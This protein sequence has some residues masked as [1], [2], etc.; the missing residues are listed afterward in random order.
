MY[1][2]PLV[3]LVILVMSI[4]LSVS[5][6]PAGPPIE[7]IRG[8]IYGWCI[9]YLRLP[10]PQCLYSKVLDIGKAYKFRDP[11]GGVEE[12]TLWPL[13]VAF[14]DYPSHPEKPF[15]QDTCPDDPDCKWVETVDLV[16]YQD[17]FG[18]WK[19]RRL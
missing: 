11:I 14:Y 18:E 15:G 4:I 17:S 10:N 7:D 6:T 12:I 3:L 16:A 2:S 19:V 1:K 9:N 8:P 5:C 13:R